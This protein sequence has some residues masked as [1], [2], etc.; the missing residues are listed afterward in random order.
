MKGDAIRKI[1]T[2]VLDEVGAAETTLADLY[3]GPLVIIPAFELRSQRTHYFRTRALDD[4]KPRLNGDYPLIDAITASALSAPL[5][6]GEVEAPNVQWIYTHPDG[7]RELH[8]GAVFNDGGQGYHNCTVELVANEAL[9]RGWA[10]GKTSD[11]QV[12]IIS[13]GT[14]N[15]F[16]AR[17]YQKTLDLLNTRQIFDFKRGQARNESVASQIA[18]VQEICATNPNYHLARFDWQTDNSSN[19]DSF[20]I[21]D[22]RLKEYVNAAETIISGEPFRT[23]LS[24]IRALE[25]I[26]HPGSL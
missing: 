17:D 13:L 5:I 25:R 23:L 7:S 18:A 24:N 1:I 16:P 12:L 10:R 19:I 3:R 20:V 22:N 15:D 26:N 21:T 6:F 8:K 2:G 9:A 14:G 4:S 11:E